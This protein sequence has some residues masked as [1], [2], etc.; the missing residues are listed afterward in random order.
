MAVLNVVKNKI[1][2]GNQSFV[3]AY[4]ILVYASFIIVKTCG[5]VKGFVILAIYV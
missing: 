1:Y 5:F 2:Q 4:F 3:S